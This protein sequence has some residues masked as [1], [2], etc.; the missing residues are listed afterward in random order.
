MSNASTPPGRRNRIGPGAV[1]IARAA[2]LV[3]LVSLS[4]RALW[5]S[6]AHVTPISDFA[7]YER[8][9]L[10]ILDKGHWGG[11]YR[12]PGWPCF[13]AGVYAV[14][15]RSPFAAALVSALLG[16]VTSGLVVLLAS[17]LVSRPASILA[18]LLHAL[19]P[20][21]LAYTPLLA[22]EN[23]AVPLVV[24][25]TLLVALLDGTTG[26]RRVAV[27]LAAG[28]L[29]GALIFVRP[30]AVFFLP[31]FFLLALYS[32]TLR[33]WRPS[34]A[35]LLLVG[36]ALAV[37]PWL[38][39]NQ[40]VLGAP[41][42]AL[43]GGANLLMGNNDS[44][45][46]GGY[47][48]KALFPVAGADGVKSDAVY[49]AAA[50]D[51]IRHNPGRYLALCRVR[52][53][54]LLGT[55]ADTWAGRFLWPTEDNDRWCVAASSRERGDPDAAACWLRLRVK[56]EQFLSA[57]RVAV[58]PLTLVGLCL[59]IARW[60]V[61]AGVIAPALTY[62]TACLLPSHKNVSVNCRIHCYSF[63]WPRCWPRQYSAR[64]TSCWVA[65][66]AGAERW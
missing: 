22:S 64:M 60:R 47:F 6:F 24:M 43:N 62:L 59:S 65:A 56:N 40:R 1:G 11:A 37:T 30:A 54:R 17:R 32:A 39:R 16:A 58:A 61:F 25:V 27:A 50:I 52:A 34:S 2:L 18:G 48:D 21:A 9:A 57:V 51:W 35:L 13:L 36:T 33:H 28:L 3:A 49:R 10:N 26:G 42:L 31:A 44:T 20:T 66:R 4:V 41:L 23:L 14:L 8:M 46:H 7:D 63:P 53:C 55:K 38:L 29:S 12:T 15:G 45:P 19:S 5:V